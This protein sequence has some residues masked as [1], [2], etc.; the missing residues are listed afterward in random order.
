[1]IM[2]I[3]KNNIIRILHKTSTLDL[4]RN[5]KNGSTISA[6]IVERIN[7]REA[8]L[9]IAG[10]RVR[11]EFRRGVPRTGSLCLILESKR[12]STF[13]F[14]IS[15]GI[16]NDKYISKLLEFTIFNIDNIKEV[17]LVE[18]NRYIDNSLSGIFAFNSYLMKIMGDKRI[19]RDKWGSS[20][21]NKLLGYGIKVE[22]LIPISYLFCGCG[23][24]NIDQLLSIMMIL[25]L[26]EYNSLSELKKSYKDDRSVQERVEKFFDE[27]ERLLNKNNSREMIRDIIGNILRFVNSNIVDA[28]TGEIVY[29]NDDEFRSIQ[30]IFNDDAVI[31][32]LELSYL[33]D[34]EILMKN[35]KDTFNLTIFC[36]DNNS[37]K[38][39][40]SDVDSLQSVLEC[41]LNKDVNIQLYN[42]TS[43]IGKIIE[44]NT[45][46]SLNSLLDIKV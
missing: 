25:G 32:S 40:K 37:I 15:E 7:A 34:I 20:I 39:L 4:L 10:N 9:E 30:Y 3:N 21:L 26:P 44:I 12:S 18:L 2:K 1:M 6:K 38:A 27:I 46:L 35:Y 14:R 41:R 28:S 24:F 33:G 16:N 11:V 43:V 5:I 23:G 42:I 36:A 8:I 19:Y 22:S 31:F 17:S 13:F 45:S 29:F